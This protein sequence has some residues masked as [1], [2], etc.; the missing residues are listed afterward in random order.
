M[1]CSSAIK[2]AWL[3]KEFRK[4]G[5]HLETNG[6][7][8]AG[9]HPS[10]MISLKI[11]VEGNHAFLSTLARKVI[12]FALISH[13]KNPLCFT[14]F[15]IYIV[16][17]NISI[18]LFK[19]SIWNHSMYMLHSSSQSAEHTLSRHRLLFTDNV[20]YLIMYKGTN[21]T[22]TLKEELCLRVQK[23]PHPTNLRAFLKRKVHKTLLLTLCHP[24]RLSGIQ[25]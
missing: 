5:T 1:H 16:W 4:F 22:Y 12:F 8:F 14:Y 2:R 6:A 17:I 20:L 19:R 18:T 23:P 11:F 7:R 15:Q 3:I 24:P 13:Q 25:C 10:I 9:G 21:L